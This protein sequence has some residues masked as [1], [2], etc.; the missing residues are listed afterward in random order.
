MR[1]VKVIIGNLVTLC[2]LPI[3]LIGHGI[4]FLGD[5]FYDLGGKFFDKMLEWSNLD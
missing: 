4:L 3:A 5:W 2:I 1:Y